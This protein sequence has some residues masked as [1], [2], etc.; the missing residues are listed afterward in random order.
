MATLD[1]IGDESFNPFSTRF[2]RPDQMQYRFPPGIDT[3]VWV[4]SLVARLQNDNALA[5]IG[6]HGTGKTTLLHFLLPRL[7]AHFHDVQF[8]RLTSSTKSIGL[9]AAMRLATGNSLIVLDGFEQLPLVARL[10]MI[11]RVRWGRNGAKL[12]VTA[13]RKQWLVPT[14]F[15]TFWDAQIV[16]QLT[17]EKLA[18]LPKPQQT[19][20]QLIAQRMAQQYLSPGDSG[21]ATT[22]S[23]RDYWFS[24]YDAYEEMRSEFVFNPDLTAEGR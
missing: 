21:G 7:E 11:T 17:E 22:A 6:P 8:V 19:A 10:A 5:V 3:D 9:L 20:M 2:V 4:R 14:V 16:R 12:L 15:S 24:L 23:V 1:R 18:H 13:H